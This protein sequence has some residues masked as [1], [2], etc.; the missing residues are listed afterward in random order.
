MSIVR[1][2]YRNKA[3]EVKSYKASFYLR[4]K[5]CCVQYIGL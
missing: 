2:K 1:R 3:T 5:D 4:G